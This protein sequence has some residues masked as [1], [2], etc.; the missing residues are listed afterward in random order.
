MRDLA[1]ATERLTESAVSALRDIEFGV[2]QARQELA[3][4]VAPLLRGIAEVLLPGLRSAALRSHMISELT[5]KSAEFLGGSWTIVAHP[6]DGPTVQTAIE[7]MSNL[8][9]EFS[10]TAEPSQ[11]KGTIA[12]RISGGGLTVDVP[13]FLANLSDTLIAMSNEIERDPPHVEA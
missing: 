8:D 4:S 12:C 6:D 10:L 2:V 1:E 3:K 7:A 9:V 13:N 11:P 5:A